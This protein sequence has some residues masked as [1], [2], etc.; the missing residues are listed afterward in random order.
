M[1]RKPRI[2]FPGAVYHV[3]LRGNAGQDIF[4][5]DQDR[6]RLYLFLQ[7][8]VEKFRCRIHAFCLMRNHLHLIVQVGDVPLSRIMQNLS[9]RYTSWINFTQ[10]RTGH[11]FQ[12]RYKALLVDADSY[13]LEL[14]RYIHLNPVRAGAV[15]APENYPWSGH[16]GYVGKE[17]IPWLTTDFVLA[18]VSPSIRHARQAYESF[19]RDG[20]GEGRRNEFH[21]GT[22]ERRIIGDEEFADDVLLKANQRGEREYGLHEVI[23]AVC[24]CYGLSTSDLAAPGKTRPMAEARAVSAAIV[25]ASP[26]LQLI[27]LARLL[28]RDI[29][30]LGKGGQRITAN[31]RLRVIA[32]EIM[33]QLSA[34]RSSD[35]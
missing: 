18:Q 17:Y 26:H 35:V 32:A 14:V 29:S 12:G 33:E 20:I 24:A 8:A 1:A 23:Q 15:A 31:D 16:G 28:N 30:A 27:N 19:V 10:S 2:H 4:T 11:V 34:P 25:Q 7:Y 6:Y 21:C 5:A 13:L 3:I 9:Q 22:C